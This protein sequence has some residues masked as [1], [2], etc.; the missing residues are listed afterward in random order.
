MG[1]WVRVITPMR[2]VSRGASHERHGVE[3]LERGFG[4]GGDHRVRTVGDDRGR[5]WFRAAGRPGRTFDNDGTL[6]VEQPAP[7][8]FD[9]VFRR[10][11]EELRADPSLASRQPYK[12]LVDKDQAL[13]QGVATQDPT[14]V[15]TLEEA[16]ARSW[17][18][19]RPTRSRPRRA[20]GWPR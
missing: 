8:Q 15:A 3:E 19:R 10:W 18:G 1:N 5:R 12:A 2:R 4:E 16:F 13:F 9:V 7:P 20:T 11:A 6:W 17:T 14:V